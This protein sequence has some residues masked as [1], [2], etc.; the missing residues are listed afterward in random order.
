[1]VATRAAE[2]M[3]AVDTPMR[4]ASSVFGVISISGW[5]RLSCELTLASSGRP[6]ISCCSSTAV[7]VKASPLSLTR[8]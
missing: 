6:A 8:M 3:A 7:R 2:E 4:A 1:M 5:V